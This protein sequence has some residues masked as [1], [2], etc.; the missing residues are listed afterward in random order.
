ME[1]IKLPKEVL[2]KAEL[3]GNILDELNESREGYERL[4]CEFFSILRDKYRVTGE[5][6]NKDIAPVL[7][8]YRRKSITN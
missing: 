4:A 1:I 2:E 3:V 6:W 8:K 5:Q 7:R